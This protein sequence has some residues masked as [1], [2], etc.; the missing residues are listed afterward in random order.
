MNRNLIVVCIA[1]FVLLAVV[2]CFRL[3]E[4]GTAIVSDQNHYADQDAKIKDEPPTLPRMEFNFNMNQLVNDNSIQS[5]TA[6]VSAPPEN[7]GYLL[8]AAVLALLDIVIIFILLRHILS[9]KTQ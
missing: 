9:K 4:T 6:E 5:G 3:G 2:M 7:R 1:F 8:S